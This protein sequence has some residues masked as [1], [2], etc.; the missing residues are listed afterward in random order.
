M[1]PH[2]LYRFGV[3]LSL[4][5]S[6][7][8]NRATVSIL[9]L[10]L[11]T[12]LLPIAGSAVTNQGLEWG[13]EVGDRFAYHFHQENVDFD[14]DIVVESL[15]EI[16]DDITEIQSYHG[17][18]VTPTF[19]LATEVRSSGLPQM[20]VPVGNWILWSSLLKKYVADSF[21]FDSINT[22][23][24]ATSWTW[25]AINYFLESQNISREETATFRKSDG[26]LSNYQLVFFN[27]DGF[28]NFEYRLTLASYFTGIGAYLLAGGFIVAIVAAVILYRKK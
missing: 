25:T 16:P 18:N 3:L 22:T 7:K 6:R 10:L 20:I 23:E 17:F 13:V 26:V 2:D 14:F 4:V 19:E 24:T 8:L 27:S 9:V 5:A 28:P 1:K 11:L 12:G 15:P 21:L